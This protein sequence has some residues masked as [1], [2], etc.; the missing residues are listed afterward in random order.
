MNG[1]PG[2]PGTL[3]EF[4]GGGVDRIA[5]SSDDAS[6]AVSIAALTPPLGARAQFATLEAPA[7]EGDGTLATPAKL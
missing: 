2:S 6:K 5:I 7:P 1:F 3:D 4:G